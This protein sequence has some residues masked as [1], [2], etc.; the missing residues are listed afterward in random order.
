MEQTHTREVT[1]LKIESGYNNKCP[2][3]GK[4]HR[5]YFTFDQQQQ[6]VSCFKELAG[7]GGDYVV[8]IAVNPVI[9]IKEIAGERERIQ[10]E[11]F[12][13]AGI[14]LSTPQTP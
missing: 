7:C 5:S 10:N 3:C 9:S 1:N 13:E 12:T 2:Y 8:G 6:V 14:Q 11:A 4:K